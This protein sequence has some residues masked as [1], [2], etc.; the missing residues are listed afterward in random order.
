MENN[1]REPQPRLLL[2]VHG[3]NRRRGYP[4]RAYRRQ[5]RRHAR[6]LGTKAQLLKGFRIE[7]PGRIQ[8]VRF[9]EF[10]HGIYGRAIPLPVWRARERTIFG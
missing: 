1:F 7:L 6:G 8:P 2:P 9:L 5:G 4:G 3:L 10:F